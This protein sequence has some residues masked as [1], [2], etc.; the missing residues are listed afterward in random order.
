MVLFKTPT[1]H[2]YWRAESKYFHI[3]YQKH[4]WLFNYLFNIWIISPWYSKTAYIL[5]IC[6]IVIIWWAVV[7]QFI[8]LQ[9]PWRGFILVD[10]FGVS[11][12]M[13]NTMTRMRYLDCCFKTIQIVLF[14]KCIIHKGKVNSLYSLR[15]LQNH[16]YKHYNC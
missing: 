14:A 13:N 6:M 8:R 15:N 7:T 16:Y 5:S 11:S 10:L 4:L 3:T 12:H 2:W 1:Q 9:I